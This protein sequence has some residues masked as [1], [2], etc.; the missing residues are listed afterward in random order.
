M[1]DFNY[2]SGSSSPPAAG[3]DAA[4]TSNGALA[5]MTLKAKILYP[6]IHPSK[7]AADIACEPLSLDWFLAAQTASGSRRALVPP[8]AARARTDRFRQPCRPEGLRSGR[9]PETPHNENDRRHPLR[10]RHRDGARCMVPESRLR[11]SWVLAVVVWAC[12][13]GFVGTPR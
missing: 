1:A 13:S 11:S 9:L 6:Q 12:S 10:P 5:G 2:P 3:S 7:L 4:A 8:V